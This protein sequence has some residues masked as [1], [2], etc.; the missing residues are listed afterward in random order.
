MVNV[1]DRGYKSEDVEKT[2]FVI[3]VFSFLTQNLN[4]TGIE[5]KLDS[6]GIT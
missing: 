6:K 2:N 1:S 3:D 4:P 5:R